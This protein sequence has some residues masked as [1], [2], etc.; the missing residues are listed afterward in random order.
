MFCLFLPAASGP[1]EAVRVRIAV[2][3]L[4]ET[5]PAGLNRRD[6]RHGPV[7]MNNFVRAK[8]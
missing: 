8:S 4:S 1:T 7:V 5:G 6:S 3:V 2:I